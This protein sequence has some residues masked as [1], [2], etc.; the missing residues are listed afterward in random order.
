MHKRADQAKTSASMCP[1][2]QP[3]RSLAAFGHDASGASAIEFALVAVPLVLLMLA[4]L[5]VGLNYFATFDLEYATNYGARLIRTGQVQSKG[6]NAGT[7]KA[8]VCKQLTPM[9]SCSNLQIDVK[10]FENFSSSELT[11]PLDSNGK[12]K[13]SFSFDPGTG[14]DVV[15]VRSFY[16]WDLPSILPSEINLA[17]MGNK[18][19]LIATAAFRNEPFQPASGSGSGSGS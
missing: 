15:I 10:R 11:D 6:L 16:V 4:A 7:F 2:R 5:Q 18:R 14:G 12:M 13:T 3:S 8:E 19:L 9:L 17:N 1:S